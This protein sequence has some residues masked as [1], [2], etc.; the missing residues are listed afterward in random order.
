MGDQWSYKPHD[1]YKSTH[2]LIQL[3]VEIV[4]KGGNFLLNVGPQP[5]GQLPAEAVERLEA[6][7]AWL[8]VNGEAIYGTRPIPPYKEGQVVFTRKGTAAYAIYLTG[9]EQEGLPKQ[10]TFTALQVKPGSTVRMLGSSVALDWHKS[11]DGQTVVALPPSL[12]QEPPC[13]HAF[14]LRMEL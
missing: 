12:I 1:A 13:R 9:T 11:A 3:L 7:G 4:G 8:Q 6:I 2:R 10:I 14:V 5:D